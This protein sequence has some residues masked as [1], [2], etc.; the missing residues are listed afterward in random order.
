MSDPARFYSRWSGLYDRLATGFPGLASARRAAADALAAPGDTVVEIGCGTGANL[1]YLRERVGAGG[2]VLG[3]D[4][5]P[6]A[7][8]RARE[9]VERAG[10]EN[11][12]LLRADG[13]R[14]PVGSVD[15]ILGSFVVG[16]FADPAAAV[17][18][19]RGRAD[20]V[21]LLCGARSERAEPWTPLANALFSLFV[22]LANPGRLRRSPVSELD[23]K[24]AAA[25][26]ALDAA[27]EAEFLGGLV[28]LSV[29]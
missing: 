25:R 13:A 12:H 29:A 8:A 17:T 26:G 16:M 6:G 28:T 27:T 9:R 11:V 14:P 24:V 3:I 15:A 21:G 5:A 2:T 10:W 4:V 1:P 22:R 23:R 7:L 19:W 18:A 20:R